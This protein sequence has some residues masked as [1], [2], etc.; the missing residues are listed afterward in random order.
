ELQRQLAAHGV[1]TDSRGETL[2]LGPAPYLSDEQ[3]DA[4]MEQLG[5]LARSLRVSAAGAAPSTR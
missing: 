3:L 1:M 5:D 4:A 2:R